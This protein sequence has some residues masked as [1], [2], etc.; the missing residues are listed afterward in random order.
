MLLRPFQTRTF[1]KRMLFPLRFVGAAFAIAAASGVFA[2]PAAAANSMQPSQYFDLSHWKLTLPVDADGGTSGVAAELQP[3]QLTG[4]SSEWFAMGA[5]GTTLDFK[6]PVDGATT[7]GSHYPRSELREMRDPDNDNVN[8]TLIDTSSLQAKCAVRQVP[9]STGKVV[10]GQ[11]HGFQTRPLVKLVYRYSTSSESGSVYAVIDPAPDATST[12]VLPLAW[13]IGLGQAFSYEIHVV[14]SVLV[15]RVNA[16]A[17]VDYSVDQKWAG[18]GLYFKVGDYV[19][20]SGSSDTDGGRVAFYRLI[21]THPDNGLAITTRSLSGAAS[22]NAYSQTLAR[23]GGIGD[24]SWSV[25]NGRL[26]GGLTLNSDGVLSG[27]PDPVTTDT[28]YYFSILV[29]DETGDTAARNYALTV[30]APS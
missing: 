3:S 29:T 15:M 27:T 17:W 10:V 14:S 11:I 22:N 16:N 26:P 21:A 30:A 8:W 7:S 19:Q 18:I 1:R 2:A 13:G 9:S 23:S 6:A 12:V 24:A 25:V 4:Y 20:A 5:S 28:T